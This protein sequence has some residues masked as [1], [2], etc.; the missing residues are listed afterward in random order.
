MTWLELG[1]HAL[2][3][4]R[5]TPGREVARGVWIALLPALALGGVVAGVVGEARVGAPTGVL[6]SAPVAAGGTVA[7]VLVAAAVGRRLSAGP[8]SGTSAPP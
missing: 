1:V 5:E 7:L 8:P 6:V 2:R 3:L 4:P